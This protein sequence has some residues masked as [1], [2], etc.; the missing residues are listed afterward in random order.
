[1]R[2]TTDEYSFVLQPSEHGV[3]V[4]TTHDIASG[5]FLRLFGDENEF[6][7]R[8]RRLPKSEVPEKL[9]GYCMDR[10]DTLIAPL[11]FGEMPV[12]WYLNH[13][14]GANAT[15]KDFK[16][17]AGRDIA[18]GEEILIDYNSLDEPESGRELFYN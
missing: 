5:T 9:H 11:D 3:G 13:S 10:G 1:M 14:K 17:Y 6:E 8:V 12:G 7:H 18:E 15:H 2:N 4:F 16:W